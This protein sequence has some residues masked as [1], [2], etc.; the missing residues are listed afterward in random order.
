MEKWSK[1]KGFEGYIGANDWEVSDCCNVRQFGLP[2]EPKVDSQGYR[3]IQ[4]CRGGELI[5]V[6]RLMLLAF[7]GEPETGQIAVCVNGAW[8][9]GLR[10][11][12]VVPKRK[13]MDFKE[14]KK[15]TPKGPRYGGHFDE[16]LS[17]RRV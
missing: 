13:L 7:H 8:R 17:K 11:M 10:D 2:A 16:W 12:V 15:R 4:F 14:K 5:R 3:Y 1:I 6:H 9:W